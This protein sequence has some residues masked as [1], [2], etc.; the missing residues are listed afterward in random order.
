M[1]LKDGWEVVEK[2]WYHNPTL[3]VSVHKHTPTVWES[4]AT[5]HDDKYGGKCF[6]T[7]TAAMEDAE[8]RAEK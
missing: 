2:E 5:D 3:N 6:K 8:K 4:V 7:L 1:K